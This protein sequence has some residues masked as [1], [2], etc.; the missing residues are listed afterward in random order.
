MRLERVVRRRNHLPRSTH[1]I[2][3][4][5]SS[6]C[7]GMPS[8]ATSSNPPRAILAPYNRMVP[9]EVAL[10]PK[11]GTCV[12]QQSF[13][14]QLDGRVLSA[15]EVHVSGS[16]I[17]S[18]TP[19]RIG[20]NGRGPVHFCVGNA[21]AHKIRERNLDVSCE[22]AQRE[23]QD[24]EQQCADRARQP[25]CACKHNQNEA[26]AGPKRCYRSCIDMLKRRKTS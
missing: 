5:S 20:G 15:P 25:C 4:S 26:W 14:N 16:G 13:K 18:R 24:K 12:V 8:I 17:V 9:G 21:P 22:R 11:I 1:C 2:H 10:S 19:E 7:Q 3:A 6:D 23:V